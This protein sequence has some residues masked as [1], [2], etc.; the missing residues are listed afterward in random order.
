MKKDMWEDVAQENEILKV[1]IERLEKKVNRYR[2]EKVPDADPAYNA[3]SKEYLRDYKRTNLGL[4][5]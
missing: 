1:K 4:I 3:E 5:F 2:D